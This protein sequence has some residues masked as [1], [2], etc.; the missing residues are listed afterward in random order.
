LWQLD[1]QALA[2]YFQKN[3]ISTVALQIIIDILISTTHHYYDRQY[4]YL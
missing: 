1:Y 3:L 4:I 2:G